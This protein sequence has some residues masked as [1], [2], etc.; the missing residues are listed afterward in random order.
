MSVSIDKENRMKK[1]YLDLLRVIAIFFVV[2]NHTWTRGW[3]L[4]ALKQESAWYVVYLFW[5]IACK[6]AVPIFWMI[7]GALLLDKNESFKELFEKRILRFLVVLV[8]CSLLQYLYGLNFE[9]QLFSL[10]DFLVGLYSSQYA[11]A[12]WYLYAY[13]GYLFILPL[14]RKLVIGMNKNDFIYLIILRLAIKAVIPIIQFI[15]WNGEININYNFSAGL[16]VE[17]VIFYPILGYCLERFLPNQA[18]KA[19][20]IICLN[21]LGLLAIAACMWLTNYFCVYTGD[22]SLDRNQRFH[23]VLI[24]IPAM[25]VFLTVRYW[26]LKYPPRKQLAI[27]MIRRCGGGYIWNNVN[28][29]CDTSGNR[30]PFLLASFGNTV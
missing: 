26:M 15:L 4:F 9:I 25:A 13:L 10:S 19:N 8:V 5:S 18:V 23:T 12:Y 1:L 7:S 14:L 2:F 27:N 20:K 21:V 11:T 3:F 16:M 30:K 28:G 29:K 24:F 6:I 22:W 17:D